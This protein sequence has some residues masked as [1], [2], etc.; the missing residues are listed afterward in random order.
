CHEILF[1]SSRADPLR[2]D[3]RDVLEVEL[4][5]Q[6]ADTTLGDDL[7]GWGHLEG[8]DI[9]VATDRSPDQAY[10][11]NLLVDALHELRGK[12]RSCKDLRLLASLLVVSDHDDV[13]VVDALESVDDVEERLCRSGV[14]L[15]LDLREVLGRKRTCDLTD[16]VVE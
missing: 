16:V 3:L 8:A 12:G 6:V 9:A 1:H 5:R 4:D 13:Q 7:L 14:H 2:E 11:V 10:D 15:A